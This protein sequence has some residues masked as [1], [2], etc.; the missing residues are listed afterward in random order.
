MAKKKVWKVLLIIFII[1]VVLG[2]AAG[3]IYYFMSKPKPVSVTTTKVRRAD[4]TQ[5][6]SATGKIEAEVEVK[7][8]SETSGEIILIEVN[9]GD[10]VKQGQLLAKIRPDIIET[11]LDQFQAAADAA[12]MEIA[13][14]EAEKDRSESNL[15]RIAELYKKEFASKDEFERAQA[16][17]KQAASSYQAAFARYEQALASLKQ[18]KKNALRTTITSP[19]DGV[20]TKLS[21]EVGETVL[22]TVQMQ[23]TE[24]MRISD[25]SVMNSVVEVDENDIVLVE[26]G[27]TARVEV[28]ALKDKILTGYVYEIGHSAL[29]SQLGSQDQTTNFE[30]KIRLTDID[31]RLLPGMTCSAKIETETR[32]DALVVP[33][34][35]VT[36]R[37]AAVDRTPDVSEGG[38]RTA[39]DESNRISKRPPS[40]VFIMKGDTA[41]IQPVETGISDDN[42]MYEI[43]DGLEEGQTI[44][45]GSFLTV[46]K[47]LQDGMLV[48]IDSTGGGRKRIYQ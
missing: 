17:Y 9:E 12:K 1:I 14:R 43:K 42:G 13:V 10:T 33:L 4:I 47:M 29:I 40:V 28:D 44:I 22:G 39:N 21:V 23:G 5:T 27:D 25:L 45:S 2:A 32:K 18:I 30:V 31:A 38:I 48:Q 16:A 24:M 37:N 34:A 11:Q 36:V 6:V 19:I 3:T 35:A 20:V 26:I 8:S 46:S 41:K 15:E 7:I